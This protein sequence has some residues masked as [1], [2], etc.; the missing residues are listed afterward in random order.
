[1]PNGVWCS[2]RVLVRVLAIEADSSNTKLIQAK[3]FGKVRDDINEQSKARRR[4]M[5]TICGVA[6]SRI[7]ER[8]GNR[9][10]G[11]T[12]LALEQALAA[13]TDNNT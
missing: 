1:V 5:F 13:P 2:S 11:A 8:D 9:E 12:G 3:Y 4:K 10:Q 7:R 6:C